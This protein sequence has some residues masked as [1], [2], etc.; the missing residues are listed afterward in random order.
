MHE[1]TS[2]L[3]KFLNTSPCNFLAVKNLRSRLDALGFR[4]L[5][6]ADAWN[7]EPGGR[8]YVVK[9]HSA[10]FAFVA[11]L[12]RPED[13]YKIICAHSD[14]PGFRVKPDC[15]MV[16]SGNVLKLNTEV[17]GGPILYT[18][19][20]RPLSLAGRVM[21]RGKSALEPVARFVKF[22]R[23]LLTI[24]HL[25]IHF[26]RAVNEGNPL[27]KQRDMLPVMAILS[28]AGEKKNYIL[29]L[30]ARELGIDADQIL[31]YDL[32]LYDTTPAVLFGVNEEFISSGRI[33]DL[34]MV[35]CAFK[36]LTDSAG[37]VQKMTRIM[38]VFDNEETGSGT[39]QGAASPIL[40]NIIERIN[41]AL[42][43]N[44]ESYC[45][46]V[47]NSFM[48]SAD[49]GH[50]IHPNY[51]SKHDPTNHP[52]LGGGPVVKVNANC[53]YMTD[54]DSAAVFKV[55]CEEAGVPVQMFVNHSDIAG[56]STLGNILTSQIPVRGVDMGAPQ[57][58]MHSCRETAAVADHLYTIRAFTRFYTC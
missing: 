53:K 58:A 49:N 15:E 10:L 29:N 41:I 14:S 6:M 18:W 4:E 38:A 34:E 31:D 51:E 19:F 23:P 56:G 37:S 8:Y 13:G 28:E 42:G 9:N 50:A 30:L 17:Y 33:D 26:N 48:V 27:S 25:A 5:S 32:T 16:C 44:E 52:V 2:D 22:D 20:D 57:W 54:A 7:I 21:L 11:G 35:H 3:L 36:A 1:N 43:G 47:A 40:R 12:G 46:A 55:I 24:P 39:K 45:R